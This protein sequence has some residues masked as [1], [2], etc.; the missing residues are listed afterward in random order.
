MKKVFL[1]LNL[2]VLLF[3]T[4]CFN[5]SVSIVSDVEKLPD[6]ITI[7]LTADTK[8]MLIGETKAITATANNIEDAEFSWRSLNEEII[9]VSSNGVVRALAIGQATIQA[10]LLQN[11]SI[12]GNII[13][14]VVESPANIVVNGRDEAYVG[15]MFELTATVL[16]AN[17]YNDIEWSSSDAS[18]AIVFNGLVKVLSEGEV[19]I[20]ASSIANALIFGELTINIL[21]PI[22]PTTIVSSDV[23][24]IYVNQSKKI[25]YNVIPNNASR[26]VV[27]TSSDDSIISVDKYGQI[28]GKAVG[29]ATIR[30]ESIYNG[31]IY[32]EIVIEC[33]TNPSFNFDLEATVQNIIEESLPAL[34][35]V[36]KYEYSSLTNT[37]FLHSKGSGV[38][39][40]VMI[41][42][43]DLDVI[44]YDENY[45]P[46]NIKEYL[47][48]A[49]TNRHVIVN[50]NYIKVYIGSKDREYDANIVAFDDKTDI[51]V[52][53][54]KFNE[55]FKPLLFGDTSNIKSGTFVVSLGNPNGTQYYGTSTF[56]I[57]S[58]SKRYINDDLDGD[59]IGDWH[60]EY[61][62]HDGAINQG[63]SG[64]PLLNLRGEII[65]INTLKML[66]NASEAMAFAIP[67]HIIVPQLSTLEDGK[68]PVRASLGLIAMTVKEIIDREDNIHE[69]PEG[70]EHG[71][72]ITTVNSGSVGA[73]ALLEVGDIILSMNDID[74]VYI[75][76]VR[77]ELGKI[78]VG[79]N[80]TIIAS[81]YKK[82]TGTIETVELIFP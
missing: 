29:E 74:L 62:Q 1:I 21:P 6:N 9:S 69:L 37:T 19:V 44:E 16:P 17:S 8:V 5:R 33:K 26:E 65:G 66:A 22:T 82:N 57:V 27:W 60:S 20:K 79:N 40:K 3:L 77:L 76:Q 61:I 36:S 73:N 55:Y 54:F 13:L 68:T 25:N 39:Y 10:I 71:I 18:K 43:N 51:A 78:V 64:G 41:I 46:E 58:H 50:S 47:Y 28:L 56:G 52:I 35:G 4:G 2:I 32:K 14:E 38:I 63:N 34:I 11:E 81:V 31:E 49:V 7:E 30:L 59:G 70:I 45:D 53:S 15:E 72:Y 24:E 23:T 80:Q 67:S 75:Y 48:Y 42:N 12:R